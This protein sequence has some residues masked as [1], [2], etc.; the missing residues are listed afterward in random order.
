[1]WKRINW[2]TNNHHPGAL[3]KIEIVQ[4]GRRV[5]ITSEEDM[6][7]NIFH[8]TEGHFLMANSTQIS[9]CSLSNVL[10][11]LGFTE[12][13]AAI[14]DGLIQMPPDIND[15]TKAILEEIWTLGQQY[16]V[17]PVNIEISGEFFGKKLVRRKRAHWF[18]YVWHPFW[19][20]HGRFNNPLL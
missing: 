15:A 9:N 17:N 4:A 18:D 12:T 14:V 13:G 2:V 5:E 6:V 3:T 20:L 8:E 16:A 19:T 11:T 1:M 7:E 10:G